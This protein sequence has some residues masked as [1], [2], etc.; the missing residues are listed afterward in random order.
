MVQ[1]GGGVGEKFMGIRYCEEGVYYI[2]QYYL[3]I[4]LQ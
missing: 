3:V 2:T 4:G 1:M